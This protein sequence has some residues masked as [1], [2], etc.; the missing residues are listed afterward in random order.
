[1]I[2]LLVWIIRVTPTSWTVDSW[3]LTSKRKND[4]CF[5]QNAK[6]LVRISF[7]GLVFSCARTCPT[8]SKI[9][10]DTRFQERQGKKTL[11]ACNMSGS[12]IRTDCFLHKEK[13]ITGWT[14]RWSSW[15][16]SRQQLFFY[17]LPRS[18]CEAKSKSCAY[19]GTS[20]QI[21]SLCK[22]SMKLMNYRNGGFL[23]A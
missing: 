20:V 14:R 3:L 21:L 19:P 15:F 4:Q 2:L 13:M 22:A 7:G 16:E 10:S 5:D 1:V 9:P 8:A 12:S 23:C 11:S 17:A 18:Y 6:Q